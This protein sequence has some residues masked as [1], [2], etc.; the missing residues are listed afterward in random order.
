MIKVGE[1]MKII[2]APDSFKE[3]MSAIEA[4]HS[5]K[6]AIL[7]VL[8]NVSPTLLPVADGGEGTLEVL[9]YATNG[10]FYEKVV[11]GPLGEKVTARYAILG[12][13]R[14]A[15][16][17]MAE[18]SGLH[19]VPPTLRN[20]FKTTSYGTGELIKAALEH[21]ID[22]LIVTI[23]G[24]ATN[25]CGVGMLQ[26]LGVK[27]T[28]KNG[29]EISYGGGVLGDVADIDLSGLPPKLKTIK[30]SIACDV[31]N[32]LIGLNG[33]TYIYGPQKGATPDIIEQLERNVSHFAGIIEK[34]TGYGIADI[35]GSGAAGGLGAALLVC[36]GKLRPGIQL[37]L[38]AL[39]FDEIISGSD[40]IFT[41]EGKIDNQTPNGK[42]IDGI[43][44][45]ANKAEI[46][47]IAF[48]GSIKEGY[49]SLYKEGLLSAHCIVQGPCTLEEALKNGK[50]NLMKSVENITRILAGNIKNQRK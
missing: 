50:T 30:L 16:V 14:T 2:L 26:A 15:M 39:K 4:C 11:V 21:D 5:M 12:D 36:G 45:R 42:V 8:P 31:T 49:E 9:T 29:R 27:V 22:H 18:A 46:P 6:D 44:K 40:V 34:V 20:P 23:G 7:R 13:K 28:D 10:T 24:S 17:E 19:L 35:P 32:P 33:A 1:H 48:V 41:G 25:D 47:V 3:C 37:V 43:V 38:D